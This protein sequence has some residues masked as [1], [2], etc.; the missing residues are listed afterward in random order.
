[1]DGRVQ[2]RCGKYTRTILTPVTQSSVLLK[3]PTARGEESR[4]PYVP[5]KLTSR[6]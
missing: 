4:R 2:Y 5:L 6:E 3:T 1:M